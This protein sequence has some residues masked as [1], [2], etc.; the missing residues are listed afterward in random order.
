MMRSKNIKNFSENETV[1]NSAF[2]LIEE[3]LAL[4]DQEHKLHIAGQSK[5][6]TWAEAEQI[7]IGKESL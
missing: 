7:I 5:S 2:I 4:L 1:K 6:Y 3:Q